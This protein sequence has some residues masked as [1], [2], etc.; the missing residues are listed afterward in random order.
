MGHMFCTAPETKTKNPE[1][2][3][4]AEEARFQLNRR[5]FCR[6]EL[7]RNGLL[8]W[9]PAPLQL[10]PAR[11]EKSLLRWAPFARFGTRGWGEAVQEAWARMGQSTHQPRC[12]LSPV[13]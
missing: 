8:M 13:G 5:T 7:S 4:I 1:V 12:G 11:S 2:H 3:E 10:C 6:P 9:W